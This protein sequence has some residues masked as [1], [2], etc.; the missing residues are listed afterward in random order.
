ME[1][2]IA[3]L[4]AATENQ[5][6]KTVFEHVGGFLESGGIFIWC[7]LACSLVAVAVC[8]HRFVELRRSVVMPG[9]LTHYVDRIEL[10]RAEPEDLGRL[11]AAAGKGDSALAKIISKAFALRGED[12][13]T[14]RAGV[15]ATAREQ[16][17]R[18]QRGQGVLEVVIT[19]APLLGLLGTVSGL[20]PVFDVFG[21]QD[22]DVNEDAQRAKMAGGIAE[23]LSTTIA[24]LAV[25]IPVVIAHSYLN[26]KIEAMSARMEVILGIVINALG[27]KKTS[28]A[29]AHESAFLPPPLDPRQEL[30][31]RD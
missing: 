15:E 29:I 12:A 9:S 16:V 14:M 24:G 8:I 13:D 30:E 31:I 26:K 1:D 27:S 19:I 7:I 20:I 10:K 18:L 22:V 11:G 2:W 28:E 21:D 23:A 25:A 5:D 4:A 17:V 3:L 6:Q